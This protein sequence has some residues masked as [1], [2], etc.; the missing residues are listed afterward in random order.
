MGNKTL[1]MISSSIELATGLALIAVPSLVAS[2][3]LSVGLTSGG[4]AVGRVGGLGL[5]S[6]AIACWPQRGGPYA[7]PIRALFLYNLMAAFYLGYLR[8]GGE[9]DSFLLLPAC[10]LHGI[11]ALLFGRLVYEGVIGVDSKA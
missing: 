7:Q 8:I 1:L 11:L 2:V 6:L 5:V 9:F 3:L 4:M 10:A